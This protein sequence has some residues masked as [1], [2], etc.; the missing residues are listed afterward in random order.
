M[1][2]KS[3]SCLETKSLASSDLPPDLD[4]VLDAMGLAAGLIEAPNA[5]TANGAAKQ[6]A[7]ICTG[8]GLV[9]VRRLV[10]DFRASKDLSD[11]KEMA[12]RIYSEL[13]LATAGY[14]VKAAPMGALV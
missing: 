8:P 5:K 2:T 13:D 12:Q 14:E 1:T 9:T 7:D 3:E 11:R 4:Q 6:I 10:A